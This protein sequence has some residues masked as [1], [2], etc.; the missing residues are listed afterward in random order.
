VPLA[1]LRRWLA[2]QVRSQPSQDS[3]ESE[4]S[5]DASAITL[6]MWEAIAGKYPFL[7]AFTDDEQRRLIQLAESFIAS[8]HFEGVGGLFVT[9]LIRAEIALQACIPILELGLSCYQ[10]WREV[11][12]Y[13]AQFVPRHE[14]QDEFGIVHV[15]D[16]P[17][18]GEAWL[19]GPVLL[20]YED[21]EAAGE[22]F[23]YNVVI[24]EFA[25]KLDMLNG[26]ANGVPPLHTD[27]DGREWVQ[28][29]D[30]GYRDFCSR[31]DASTDP[32][33]DPT[34]SIDPYASESPAEFFAVL[35]EAFFDTPEVL[36]AEY[37]D[38]YQ[39]LQ[40]FYRQ[41]P[42]RRLQSATRSLTEF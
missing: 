5:R 36:N 23:G 19:G 20:S 40:R 30:K 15:S 38:I 39:Q 41:D 31:V 28:I 7:K 6:E 18:A 11:V 26:D 9:P 22:S 17:N 24:H 1:S 2:D 29:F 37:P 12:V 14:V 10:D 4:P 33:Q 32:E 34:I 8:K 16:L 21:V 27:M 42:L 35:S 3:E 13:P 25:H